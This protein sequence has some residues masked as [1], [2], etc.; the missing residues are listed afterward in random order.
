MR[1]LGAPLQ[2]F[3]TRHT[4]VP[5]AYSHPVCVMG[6]AEARLLTSLK[7]QRLP[8]STRRAFFCDVQKLSV[9]FNAESL[10][11]WVTNH[12]GCRTKR[13]FADFR[14]TGSADLKNE[15]SDDDASNVWSISL[16][17]KS[18]SQRE[19]W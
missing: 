19:D 1:N 11:R 5:T 6:V 7:P 15:Y 16:S 2:G 9:N 18:A 14:P 10:R 17:L 8:S 4:R 3:A 13:L 12:H